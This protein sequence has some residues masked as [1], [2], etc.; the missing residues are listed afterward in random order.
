MPI[1]Y[2]PILE[3][4]GFISSRSE[5]VVNYVARLSDSKYWS[6]SSQITVPTNADFKF[7][8]RGVFSA[9][10]FYFVAT[11]DTETGRL[12]ISG[13]SRNVYFNSSNLGA[14]SLS[15]FSLLTDGL[16]HELSF[17]REGAE[18]VVLVDGVEVKRNTWSNDE[19]TIDSIA[20]RWGGV[21]TIP[22]LEDYVYNFTVEV[23]GVVTNEIKLTNKEQGA[24]Q[25]P[26]VGS[27][28][29]TLIGYTGNEW[30]LLE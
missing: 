9:N 10:G 6:L 27:I 22:Y 13:D 23:D 18:A 14:L 17:V 7:S 11:K 26:S 12:A 8:A 1:L 24:T 15:D 4:A 16:D 2:A 29:A 19:F 20:S 5:P 30:E 21:T 3:Q 28:S 25:S